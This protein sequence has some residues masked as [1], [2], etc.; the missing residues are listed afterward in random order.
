M[1]AV[2]SVVLNRASRPRWWGRDIPG[3]CRAPY[4]FSCWLASDPN[5]V[6]LLAVTTAD[7]S[8]AVAVAVARLAVAAGLTDI[9]GGADS[10]YASGSPVPVWAKSIEPTA[11]IGGH[12]FYRVVP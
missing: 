9:T 12:R 10:Y 2:C 4:Q 7:L 11:V 5:R 1:S 3:V 8:F 6:K